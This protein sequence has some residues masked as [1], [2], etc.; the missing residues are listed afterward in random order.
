MKL[1]FSI[2]YQTEWG[3][4]LLVCLKYYAVDGS[5]RSYDVPMTTDDG[6]YWQ[7]ETSVVESRRSPLTSFTYF[8]TVTDADGKELRREWS[9]VPRTYSFDASKNYRLDDQWR[10]YPLPYHLYSS[11]YAVTN[12]LPVSDRVEPLRIP[13]FRKTVLFR[14]SAPQLLAGQRIALLGSHP[15]IGAWSPARW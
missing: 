7:A 9:M 3:Q 5:V 10:D 11:A 12:G 13:L 8:Y 15:S 4:Q 14:V 2:H 6:D 1:K